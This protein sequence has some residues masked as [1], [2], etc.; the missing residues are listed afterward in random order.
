[1]YATE[2][3]GKRERNYKISRLCD[4]WKVDDQAKNSQSSA[5]AAV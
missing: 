5:T 2:D 1:M 4:R 3:A